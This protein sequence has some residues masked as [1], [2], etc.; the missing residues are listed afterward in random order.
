MNR[1]LTLLNLKRVMLLFK[2][3]RSEQIIEDHKFTANKR[4]LNQAII[5]L[6]KIK[7]DYNQRY[8]FN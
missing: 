4:N 3:E 7:T 8:G 5:E 2:I 1:E 6:L